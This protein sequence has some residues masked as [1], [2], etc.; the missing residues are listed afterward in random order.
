MRTFI[1]TILFLLTFYVKGQSNLEY[2]QTHTYEIQ[3]LASGGSP[4]LRDSM[5]INVP[6][7]KTIKITSAICG[8]KN[9]SNSVKLQIGEVF[10]DNSLLYDG[11]TNTTHRP[12]FPFWLESGNYQLVIQSQPSGSSILYECKVSALEFN[13][14]Q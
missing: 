11:N 10:I 7:G 13:I 3:F 4:V 8:G 6:S 2:S 1:L 5:T 14:T 12:H 9:L